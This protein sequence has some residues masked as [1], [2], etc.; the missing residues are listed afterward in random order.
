MRAGAVR[1]E[2]KTYCLRYSDE[3]WGRQTSSCQAHLLCSSQ[4][5]CVSEGEVGEGCALP[6]IKPVGI[7]G[8]GWRLRP[9][10]PVSHST[11]RMPCHDGEDKH[12]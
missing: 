2:A 8:A 6:G 4:A 11:R 9:V 5:S 3:R 12:N 7:V 1:E 10:V